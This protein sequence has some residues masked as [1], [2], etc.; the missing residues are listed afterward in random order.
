MK[1]RTILDPDFTWEVV[2]DE[3]YEVFRTQEAAKEYQR[4]HGG[5]V[6]RH[7]EGEGVSCEGW[8]E[9]CRQLGIVGREEE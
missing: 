4:I 7:L 5:K 8:A 1:T 9:V 2:T 3:R 6:Q